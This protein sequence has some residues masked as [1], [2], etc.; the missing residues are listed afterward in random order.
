MSNSIYTNTALVNE[1]WNSRGIITNNYVT[2]NAVLTDK[3]YLYTVV[4]R[5]I[6]IDI[7]LSK[8]NGF[9]WFEVGTIT[10]PT[11]TTFKNIV[12]LN[13][14]GPIFHMTV[15][16]D[17][18][19]RYQYLAVYSA[20]NR[21]SNVITLE[22]Q[23]VIRLNAYAIANDG[24]LTQLTNDRLLNG[25]DKDF[26]AFDVDNTTDA[27]YFT[28]T[29]FDTLYVEVGEP[30][31]ANDYSGLNTFA[32]R[33]SNTADSNYYNIL[34]TNAN[35]DRTLDILAIKYTRDPSNNN[36]PNYLVYHNFRADSL[37]ISNAVTIRELNGIDAKDINI[38]RDGH[39]NI[40]AL[41]TEVPDDKTYARI[42]YSM[43]K[44][45]G[46][47]WSSPTEIKGESDNADFIDLPLGSPEGR[48]VLMGCIQGFLIG[49]VKKRNNI[50]TAYVRTLVSQNGSDYELSDQKVAAS[51][52]TK[53][54]TGIRFFAPAAKGKYNLNQKG[55]IRFI[56]QIG[57]GD[58]VAQNDNI[59]VYFGQKLLK[60]EAFAES[61]YTIRPED[62]ALQ[63][64]LLCSFNLIGSTS[65]NI[66]YYNEGL[67]GNITNKYL[68]SFNRFGTSVE[69]SKYEP[70]QASYTDNST[71]YSLD[72]TYF[73]KVFVDDIN[74]AL[75]QPSGN[76]TFDD[77]IER[78]T[79][80][81]HLPPNFHL[82]RTF[83][84]NDGN[85]LKRT[86]WLLKFGGNEYELTQVVPKFV[87]N[88]IA[89][90]TSNAYV[91]G[92]SRDPFSRIILPS[93]T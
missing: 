43:S 68:S 21:I 57:Q 47:T 3:N 81:I 69:I 75:P 33:I 66:D 30:T 42:F 7:L 29:K 46:L 65:L 91:V 85:K 73:V 41:W 19:G 59:P 71:A 20:W 76:E 48:T 58:S 36:Y 18:D 54:V 93:E 34:K 50:G 84:L 51:H 16:T 15:Y 49:Y 32:T 70:E 64:Q 80:Q 37:T 9:T 35:K 82:G 6:F 17:K 1:S 52:A 89:Y 60:D 79:R 39:G 22:T 74:Y 8:D 44:D 14:N 63:N 86:V 40:M 72:S 28:Y 2:R 55:E 25:E 4:D 88:Q 83:K 26:L 27:I 45:N 67:I 10:V 77:Y 78:D 90:Y 11:G 92:P 62:V 23:F 31:Q 56:Y 12:G 5:G 87:D 38:E 53:D 24:S 13:T 61:I